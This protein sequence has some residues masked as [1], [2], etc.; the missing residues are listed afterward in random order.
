MNQCVFSPKLNNHRNW[1]LVED[2]DFELQLLKIL[3]GFNSA[4]FKAEGQIK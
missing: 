1:F 2:E 3:I 4:L